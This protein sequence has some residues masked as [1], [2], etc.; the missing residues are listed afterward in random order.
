V[1]T[2]IR[3]KILKTMQFIAPVVYNNANRGVGRA[4]QDHNDNKEPQSEATT[5]PEREIVCMALF[6]SPHLLF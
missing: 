1:T 2:I 3:K 6:S 4:Q 5:T